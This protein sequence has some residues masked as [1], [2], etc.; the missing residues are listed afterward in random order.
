MRRARDEVSA[1]EGTGRGGAGAVLTHTTAP[2]ARYSHTTTITH[3]TPVHHVSDAHT[4]SYGQTGSYAP[5]CSYA[6]GGSDAQTGSSAS[7]PTGPA[8]GELGRTWRGA[9]APVDA[10]TR[11]VAAAH[12][13]SESQRALGSASV[14]HGRAVNKT[15]SW[16]RGAVSAGAHLPQAAAAYGSAA[17]GWSNG[18]VDS[19]AQRLAAA[20]S[21]ALRPTERASLNYTRGG[22]Q[23][24]VP[25]RGQPQAGQL[26]GGQS[27]AQRHVG[28]PPSR[29]ETEPGASVLNMGPDASISGA[30]AA[31]QSAADVRQ[32]R[33]EMQQLRAEMGRAA[34]TRPRPSVHDIQIVT[35]APAAG[36]AGGFKSGG[37][38]RPGSACCA[39]SGGSRGRGDISLPAGY[40]APADIGWAAVAH[41]GIPVRGAPGGRCACYRSTAER[42][43]DILSVSMLPSDD[44]RYRMRY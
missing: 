5:A 14:Q 32:L 39:P 36:A 18:L 17:G 6:H 26:L 7:A 21:Y 12:A 44:P 24:T 34:A 40:D 9:S 28:Q 23:T 42:E 13:C 20:R 33:A 3:E 4:G 11:A 27:M 41:G 25:Q 1:G 30:E 38:P 16:G 15:L 35:L 19:S 10:A 8:W 31:A 29:V 2:A 22:Q 37:R 43:R